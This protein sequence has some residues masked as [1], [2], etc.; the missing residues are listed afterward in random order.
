MEPRAS[1]HAL[2]L[3]AEHD[4]DISQVVGTGQADLITKTDVQE[5]I[6]AWNIKPAGEE[7]D[8]KPVT[9][10]DE[11]AVMGT[12]QALIESAGAPSTASGELVSDEKESVIALPS[13]EEMAA[14]MLEM[15]AEIKELKAQVATTAKQV[16]S[17]YDLTD[18][19]FFI[20]KPNGRKW[21]ERKI[22]NRQAIMVD[23]TG[24]AFYGPFNE[25]EDID[26]YLQAK[27]RKRQDSAFEWEGV[28]TM[29]GREARHL[30]AEEDKIRNMQFEAEGAAPVNVLDQ[31]I[32][33]QANASYERGPETLSPTEKQPE[34]QLP[35][36]YQQGAR[37]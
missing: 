27:S 8:P 23:M 28:S 34:M 29:T 33:A 22:I 19:L 9:Q 4:I 21:Q 2:A 25:R 15:S 5:Y 36:T 30:R 14:L 20:C 31:R 37:S 1:T 11:P 18:D 7:A 10:D 12:G 3:A 32:F 24:T 17:T 35:T 13:Q 6:D 26:K 16:E